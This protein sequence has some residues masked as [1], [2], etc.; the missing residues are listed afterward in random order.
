MIPSKAYTPNFANGDYVRSY[1]SVFHA[2]NTYYNNKSVNISL[3]EYSKGYTLWG[4]DL[5]PDQC[6]EDFF[7]KPETGNIK[8]EVRFT[9]P[10]RNNVTCLVYADFNDILEIDKNREIT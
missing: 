4:F 7:Q 8:L 2:T 3:S 10:L 1:L 5:S 6:K 9:S